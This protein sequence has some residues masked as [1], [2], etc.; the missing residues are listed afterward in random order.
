MKLPV[1]F[2]QFW[3]ARQGPL[4]LRMAAVITAACFLLWQGSI[5]LDVI[6]DHRRRI[7]GTEHDVRR[8]R[9]TF[10]AIIKTYAV[11]LRTIARNGALRRFAEGKPYPRDG[12]RVRSE[13]HDLVAERPM[14]AKLRYLDATG[15]E[16]V[17]VNREGDEAVV[18]PDDELQDK[19]DRYFFQE[20][21]AL[22]AG[23][24]YISPIDLNVEQ[25]KIEEPWRPMLRLGSPITG[26]DGLPKGVV[27]LNIDAS[28]LLS[29]INRAFL[30]EGNPIQLITFEGYWVSG[31]PKEQLWGFMF[32][33][34]TTLARSDP[35]LWSQLSQSD[36]GSFSARGQHYVF[37]TLHAYAPLA[38]VKGEIPTSL[39][40]QGWK[41]LA[42]VPGIGFGDFWE[43]QNLL[44][45]IAGIAGI[46]AVAWGWSSALVNQRDAEARRR[47][48]EEELMRYERLASLGGLVAGVA[49]ELNTPIGNAVT[50]ASTLSDQAEELAQNISSGNIKRSMIDNFVE[51]MRE[52]TALMMRGL[53]RA[54][55]LIGHFKQIAVD[56]TSEQRRKF[57]LGD[58]V[59]DIVASMRIQLRSS[60]IALIDAVAD[61]IE[62]DSYPGPL[63]QVL[64]NLIT[65]AQVHAF[66][67]G[68]AG[69]ILITGRAIGPGE[70]EITVSDNGK[71]VPLEH[72][73][74]IFAP[75][76]TT[77][78]GKGG[79]GLG[80]SIVFNLVTNVLGGSI[81]VDSRLGGG[82]AMIV[83]IPIKAPEVKTE[84]LGRSYDAAA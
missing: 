12:E 20:T 14:L 13:F 42:V 49:H 21:I 60:P 37:E 83:R 3:D 54:A 29:S 62:L 65:N 36:R 72:Q 11:D 17:R 56:Q 23:A 10:D 51:E 69:T 39:V 68:E 52:G 25:G 35:Y 61:R 41:F 8:A 82:T 28:E 71:G 38:P 34:E 46:I 63:G 27:I 16:I 59:R 84:N 4:F 30:L 70:I 48:T 47:E 22:P 40:G 79:S 80:L 77:S 43:R 7:E 50:L 19:S 58:L 2:A 18:V 76:F 6:Y 33:Q 57:L 75:F 53:E 5:Y 44:L 32:G 1:R 81:R 45:A 26:S 78:L 9:E 73:S 66:G 31:V 74:R 67:E 55:T 64:I 15:M 24:L